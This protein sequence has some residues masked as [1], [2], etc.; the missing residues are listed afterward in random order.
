M[1]GIKLNEGDENCGSL[2]MYSAVPQ[3]SCLGPV[4]FS[5]FTYASKLVDVIRS[6]LLSVPVYA[7]DTLLYLIFCANSIDDQ[8]SALAA[9]EHCISDIRL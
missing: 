7:D 3:G 1:K 5:V 9:F 4:L 6:H 8:T 2:I